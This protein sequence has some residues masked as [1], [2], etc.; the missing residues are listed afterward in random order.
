MIKFKDFTFE[1]VELKQILKEI[2]LQ[3]EV[4]LTEHKN[5]LSD[6]YIVYKETKCVAVISEYLIT[7]IGLS[8][9]LTEIDIFYIHIFIIYNI[10][11]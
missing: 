8:Y 10:A 4:D 6:V 7:P 3:F 5:Y 9:T 1:K 2:E 11:K